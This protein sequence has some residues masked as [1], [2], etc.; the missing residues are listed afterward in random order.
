MYD[1]TH[2]TIDTLRR[3]WEKKYRSGGTT[4]YS[5]TRHDLIVLWK[6]LLS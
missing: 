2:N 6:S 3:I 5:T 1:I 4:V